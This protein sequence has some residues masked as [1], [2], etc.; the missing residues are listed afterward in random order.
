M[1]KIIEKSR[2]EESIKWI[3]KETSHSERTIKKVLKTNGIKLNKN[4]QVKEENDKKIPL[5]IDSLKRTKSFSSTAREFGV[6]DNA[7][8]KLLVSRGYPSHIKEILK[9][10]G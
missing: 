1:K 9:M 7:I 4:K 2:I 3:A 8:R 6:S 10:I 5:V